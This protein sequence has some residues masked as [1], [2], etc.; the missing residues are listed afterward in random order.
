M[1]S[2]A[3][4]PSF[5]GHT[6]KLLKRSF[7]FCFF[8]VRSESSIPFVDLQIYVPESQL[9]LDPLD[10]FQCDATPVPNPSY[11]TQLGAGLKKKVRIKLKWPLKDTCFLTYLV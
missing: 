3:V 11:S 8:C 1:W 5:T 10:F 6:T 9:P 2:V 7:S 4:G